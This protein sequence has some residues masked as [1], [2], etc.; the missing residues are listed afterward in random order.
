ML[1]R[2]EAQVSSSHTVAQFVFVPQERHEAHISLYLNGLVKDQ[3][4]IGFPG[5]RLQGVDFLRCILQ[6]F[7]KLF[8]LWT[9]EQENQKYREFRALC[10]LHT[11]LL[12]GSFQDIKKKNI[13]CL[14]NQLIFFGLYH[15]TP[16]S[17]LCFFFFLL[18]KDYM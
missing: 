2:L 18:Q 1:K 15:Q 8:D 10:C 4:A 9:R 3:H 17:C 7:T 14:Q 5:N 12:C 13:N 16:K 6:L 11:F